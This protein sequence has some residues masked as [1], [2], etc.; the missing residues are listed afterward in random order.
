[1]GGSAIIQ[2]VVQIV[3]A[4]L[5]APDQFGALAVMLVFVNV[6]NVITQSGLNSA[7]VQASEADD[8]DFATVF[9][10]VK[11]LAHFSATPY[12]ESA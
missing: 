8:S 1:R 6:G 10:S 4:R 11:N 3:M 12:S 5:L 2:L 7:L 9:G